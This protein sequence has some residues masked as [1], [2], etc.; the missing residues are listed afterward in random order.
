[1]F[2]A[3]SQATKLNDAEALSN[4]PVTPPK[5]ESES[6]EPQKVLQHEEQ[7]LQHEKQDKTENK[8]S[9]QVSQEVLKELAKDLEIIHNVGLNFSLHKA[10]GRT[11]VKVVNKE[12]EE[13][14]REIPS[15]EI[16]NLAARLDEM[17]GM[18]FDETV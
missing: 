4:S 1:M 18:I 16:L 5:Q 14:I 15:E 10:T 8:Q 3:I 2:E 7:V 12:T 6:M 17:V 11:M 13:L 9:Q